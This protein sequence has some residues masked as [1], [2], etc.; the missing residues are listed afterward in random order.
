MRKELK[1]RELF[2][3]IMNRQGEEVIETIYPT[4]ESEHSF[5]EIYNSTRYIGERVQRTY[6]KKYEYYRFSDEDGKIFLKQLRDRNTELKAAWEEIQERERKLK[7]LDIQ[8][9]RDRG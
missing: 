6:S 3:V 1:T 5:G 9:I 8:R 7:K 2:V 4:W